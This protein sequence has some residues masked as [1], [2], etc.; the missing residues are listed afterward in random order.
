MNPKL[1]AVGIGITT[2]DR[3]DDL[4]VTLSQLRKT[5]YEDVETIVIDDGSKQPVPDAL[6]AAFPKIRF[7]RVDRSLGLV[8]QRNRLAEMLKS[9]YYLSL[10]DDSFPEAGEIGEAVVWLENHPSVAALALQIVKGDETVGSAE[11]LGEPFPVQYFIGCGHLLRRKQFIE[12]GGYL[13]RLH[14][15]SEEIVFCLNAL[16]QGFSIYGYPGVVIRHTRTPVAR[17]SAKASRYYIRNQT[18]VGLLYFPFPFSIIR[19]LNC[20]LLLKES[21]WNPHPASLLLGWLE[22]FVCIIS[23]KK[24]S[25]R[26]SLSQ[27]RDWKALPKPWH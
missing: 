23:W 6:R 21:Q 8:V 27:F 19:A 20:L 2:R 10:D 22:S 12:L 4:A 14:Y 17:N 7:E 13:D 16:L 3:W 11:M 5:G 18:L 1:H 26:M 9:T 15:F 25:R 24:L